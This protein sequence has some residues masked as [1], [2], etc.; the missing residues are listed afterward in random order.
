MDQPLDGNA[1]ARR[2]SVE[3]ID[4]SAWPDG[5]W[6]DEPDRVEWK[7]AGLPCLIVR[8]PHHGYLCGYAA[9]P[10]GH[11]Y[12]GR[13]HND[14]DLEIG[15]NYSDFC[16]GLICHKPET[17]EPDNVFWFGFDC[18]HAFD[19]APGHEARMKELGFPPLPSFAPLFD[20]VYRTIPWVK[21]RVEKLA[22]ELAAIGGLDAGGGQG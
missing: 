4:K 1:G 16:S 8:H 14:L 7:H 12:H 9:V 15:V 21:A 6:M 13:S 20:P 5:P 18:G 10:P 17:G 19:F 2:D 11:P 3:A 22:E